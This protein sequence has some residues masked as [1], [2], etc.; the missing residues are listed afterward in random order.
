MGCKMR[1]LNK[2]DGYLEMGQVFFLLLAQ[3]KERER[4]GRREGKEGEMKGRREGKEEPVLV[5]KK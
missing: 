4:K 1:I 5:A 2:G 3:G